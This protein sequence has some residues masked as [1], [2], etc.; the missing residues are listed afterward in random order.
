[1]VLRFRLLKSEILYAQGSNT[2]ALRL[3]QAPVGPVPHAAELE[4]QR[5]T[6]LGMVSYHKGDY[7]QASENFERARTLAAAFPD[8]AVSRKLDLGR[9]LVLQERGEFA[10]AEALYRQALS[11]AEQHGDKHTAG[12]ALGNL[13]YMRMK[14]SRYDEALE[15]FERVLQLSPSTIHRAVTLANMGWC[16]YDLGD[17]D[18]ARSLFDESDKLME[19][20]HSRYRS[21]ALGGFGRIYLA[22]EMFSEAIVWFKKA[23]AS[24]RDFVIRDLNAEWL[25]YLAAAQIE[26]GDLAGAETANREAGKLYAS[27]PNHLTRV[28]SAQCGRLAEARGSLAEAESGYRS[29]AESQHFLG[30]RVAAA[31]RLALLLDRLNR[32]DDAGKEFARAAG[33]VEDKRAGMVK[34]EY[35]ITYLASAERLYRDYVEFLSSHNQVGEALRVAESSRARLLSEKLR[36][37][38]SVTSA[39][40]PRG[41]QTFARES[42]TVFLCYWTA[43][44]ASYLW[45]VTGTGTEQFRLPS[46]S[47][48]ESLV[49]SYSKAIRAER[50]L[51]ATGHPVARELYETLIQP[52]Q[53]FITPESAVFIVPDGPLHHLNFESLLVPAPRPHFWIEDVTVSVI[54]SLN[55]LETGTAS[56]PG[57]S[58]LL[59][60][61]PVSAGVQFPRLANAATEIQSVESNFPAA[62]TVAFTG[63]AAL[64]AAYA[65]AHP[66]RFSTIH[67]VTHAV[68]NYESPLDSAVILSPGG[69]SFKLYAREVMS[70]HIHAD[71]VTLS[72]CESAGTRTYSGEG[73]VGFAWAFLQAGAHNVVA[74]LWRV[75]DASTAQLMRTMYAQIRKRQIA[76]GS[77]ARC[78]ALS[79]SFQGQLPQAQLLGRLRAV[80]P[81]PPQDPAQ[82]RLG[83]EPLTPLAGSDVAH[84]LGVPRSQ[85]C[86]R[87]LPGDPPTL[88]ASLICS[89]PPTTS[90]LPLLQAHLV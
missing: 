14:A 55:V 5:L 1:M 51:V 40:N 87:M 15:F 13:G 81:I 75:D 46:Q 4:A 52:A 36:R 47:K 12:S 2:E 82:P 79:H 53:R 6:D 27:L 48:L 44:K 84:A 25:T 39:P 72:A 54:P 64:P 42:R 21:A 9:G 11:K 67:F 65:Q 88:Y 43:P 31:N 20:L 59:F 24:A 80:H 85:S 74:G 30:A 66:E 86:E 58:L 68:A 62:R 69:D 22:R 49:D 41:Y 8:S 60:G 34:D 83:A 26:M 17:L 57:R 78:Q 33:L 35:K 70:G 45:V 50:D 18:H 16:Y 32:P 29:V 28:A 71:L 10:E 37:E 61:D 76:G 90:R 89:A 63:A 73:L 3:L 38:G 19:R 56:R 77:V 23:A 7:T